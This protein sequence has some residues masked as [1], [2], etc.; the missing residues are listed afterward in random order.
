MKERRAIMRQFSTFYQNFVHLT[1]EE[2]AKDIEDQKKRKKF[3]KAQNLEKENFDGC[4]TDCA[5]IFGDFWTS[6][7]AD[8]KTEL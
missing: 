3:V 4:A 8:Q 5:T 1:A 6:L 7:E 2:Q